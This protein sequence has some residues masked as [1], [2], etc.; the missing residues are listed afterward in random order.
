MMYAAL[1]WC[2]ESH[3]ALI[4]ELRDL[5]GGGIFQMPARTP[6][7]T[8]MTAATLDEMTGGRFR[9]GLG[10][11]GPQVV[12]GWHGVPYGRPLTRTREYVEIVR[13]ILDRTDPLT[14]DGEEYQI[15][16][17]G[18]GASGLGK[19]LKRIGEARPD[20]PIYLASIG[21]Q[22]VRLTAEIADGW[23]PIFYS[24]ERAGEVFEASLREGFDRSGTDAKSARFEV[25]PSVQA[26]AA[27]DIDVARNQIRPQVALYVGGM[28][29]RNRNFYFD[30]AVRYG[31][32]REAI[33]IQDRYL[34]GDKLGAIA[35]VPDELVDEV[36]LVGSK[37][38]IRDRLEVWRASRAD[39]VAVGTVDLHT[40]RVVAEAAAM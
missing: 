32:E 8:A 7:M 31:F 5:C 24:P 6:A 4:D 12:E 33:Q 13:R 30:L 10:L 29:A 17:R 22:N 20:I 39:A 1:N 36:A 27:D 16:F 26:A 35:A 37:E 15:P 25:V 21:P 34:E 2:T 38:R 11:S 19:P 28:G 18:Q 23:L 9:L 3:S 14:F 40:L